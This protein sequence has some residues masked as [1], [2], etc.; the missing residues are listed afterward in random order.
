MK[1][2]FLGTGA[3]EGVPG[4]FCQCECCKRVR[5]EKGKNIR[6][7]AGVIIDDR[8]MI[9]FGADVFTQ[10]L[11]NDLD[12]TAV[13][14][15]VFTHSHSDHFAYED[16]LNRG[17]YA[18]RNRTLETTG[19]Y[20]NGAII[21]QMEKGL[22]EKRAL[23][24]HLFTPNKTERVGEYEVTPLL[25]QHAAGE[26]SYVLLIQKD[27]KSY[28][29]FTDSG[30]PTEELIATL[31]EKC[32]NLTAIAMDCTFST[33]EQEFFGH[34]NLSQNVKLK[35]RLLEE[36]IA[37]ENTLFYATHIFHLGGLHQEICDQATPHGIEV[38]YDG[39]ELEI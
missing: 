20:G 5:K 27:G 26:D 10:M 38:A 29:H 4:L 24:I 15:I 18:S 6:R 3:S 32:K 25:T 14:N 2:K 34:M 1:V 12:L 30:Y 36:G 16:L 31:K 19:V 9:D 8:L 21:K 7:R 28:L 23:H 22:A 11:D 33:M 35:A 39:L 37:T 13:E 17:S